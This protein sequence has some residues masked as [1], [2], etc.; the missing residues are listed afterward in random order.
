MYY[1]IFRD[2]SGLWRWVL[3]AGSNRKIAESGVGYV[4]KGE[5]QSMISLVK[6]SAGAIIHEVSNAA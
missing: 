1:T 5:C 3:Y 4:S 6:G 2:A